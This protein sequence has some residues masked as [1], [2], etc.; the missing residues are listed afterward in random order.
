MSEPK[1]S[2]RPIRSGVFV[3]TREGT[4]AEGTEI[5]SQGG[6]L[7]GYGTRI[8]AHGSVVDALV[9]CS[10]VVAGVTT[11]RRFR[12]PTGRE[13]MFQGPDISWENGKVGA[14]A[15]WKP[16]SF[17]GP[18]YVD[19]AVC[20]R[21][22]SARYFL[23]DA[24]HSLDR[25]IISGTKAPEVDMS[26][27]V[28]GGVAGETTGT[29][30]E[31]NERQTI[32]GVDFE[33]I[34]EVEFNRDMEHGES[35]SALLH[36]VVA[37]SG[38]YKMVGIF[39]ASRG[40]NRRHKGFA[41][42][43]D[44]A[45][46]ALGITFGEKPPVLPL[47]VQDG[48]DATQYTRWGFIPSPAH[49]PTLS[50]SGPA[51]RQTHRTL[52][53]VALSGHPH[54]A[55]QWNLHIPVG[56][57]PGDVRVQVRMGPLHAH[58]IAEYVGSKWGFHVHVRRRGENTWMPTLHGESLLSDDGGGFVSADFSVALTSSAGAWVEYFK[59][60]RLD[61]FEVKIEGAPANRAPVVKA[62]AT[63]NL[64][65][66]GAQVT[67]DASESE[68]PDGDALTYAWVQL[69]PTHTT[70]VT[71]TDADT[72]QATFTAPTIAAELTFR[73]T[74]TDSYG[75]I[76][77][78]TT[79]VAVLGPGLESLGTLV[80]G[81][82]T[83]RGSWTREILSVN[84][85]GRYARFYVFRLNRR[86]RVRLTLA[87]SEGTHMF[88]L[89][90]AGKK[91]A[92]LRRNAGFGNTLDSRI[93]RTLAAGDY[94]IEATTSWIGRTGDFDLNAR[95]MSSDATLSGLALSAGA[96]SPAFAADETSYA[97]SVGHAQNTITVTPTANHGQ[98]TITVKGVA[99]TSGAASD[100]LSLL[101]GENAIAVVVTAE[102]GTQR[103]YTVTVTRAAYGAA[104]GTPPTPP[105]PTPTPPTDTPPTPPPTTGCIDWGPWTD[106]NETRGCGRARMRL[107]RKHC[108]EG[109]APPQTQWVADPEDLS[110]P[111][112]RWTETSETRGQC[113][114]WEIKET[115]TRL[116]D[117]GRP[118]TQER[119]ETWEGPAETWGEWSSWS[120]TGR[121]RG[122]GTGRE[123]E[124]ERTRTSNRCRTQ[125]Q[126]RW[127]SDPEPEPEPD[128]EP[129]ETWGS[130]SAW[131]DTGNT[132][133]TDEY[134]EREQERTRTS[135]LGNTQTQTRWVTDE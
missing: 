72:A 39:F 87:S 128:P 83:A 124:Q 119:W 98:A 4:E 94:T 93:T 117:C 103:T 35:G 86:G 73:V 15:D 122:S 109:F 68:D 10:H 37:G 115:R 42:R 57:S 53:G 25:K 69:N 38:L 126:T 100:A 118:Q 20:G 26:V 46:R 127:V 3:T 130:W 36:E 133:G 17:N 89:A 82:T 1:T 111:W 90:G 13:I 41:F 88:L 40:E 21:D 49:T 120:D 64:A 131:S 66:S 71:L 76:K 55:S 91:G 123:E 92:V 106:T 104:P 78:A 6:T 30:V 44:E 28:L 114:D 77:T 116:D 112:G 50:A 84:L 96:L 67:L 32:G 61:S 45:E 22:A 81:D 23:H 110:T 108:R 79:S 24:A 54:S 102:D 56:A 16:L 75:A 5:V 19:L 59:E 52:S 33:R 43:A 101:V 8:D 48:F 105:T 2:H 27:T 51:G 58:E 63:P 9:T 14:I 121:H 34:M 134:R 29:V 85:P 60:Y 107:Q 62:V 11:D 125:T 31:V 65:A 47:H 80:E 135:N 97:A 95:L 129:P 113:D 132:R 74:V 70:T 18:N 99:T 12:N 7:T